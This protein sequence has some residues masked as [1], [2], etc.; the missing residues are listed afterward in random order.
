MSRGELG[1]DE[2]GLVGRHRAI[3]A[4]D[5]SVCLNLNKWAVMR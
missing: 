1:A 5:A 3:D 2:V 4:A